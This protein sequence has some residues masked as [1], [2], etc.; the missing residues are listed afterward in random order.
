VLDP[1]CGCGTAI[2]VAQRLGRQWIGVDL[3]HIAIAIIRERMKGLVLKVHGEP[4][5][6]AGARQLARD[7]PYGFHW[8]VLGRVGARPRERKEGAD[9]GV[10]GDLFFRDDPRSP[11]KRI[12]FSVEGGTTGPLHVRELRAVTDRGD[13]AMGVLVTMQEPTQAMVVDAAKAGFYESPWGRHP[14][15]QILPVDQILGGRGPSYPASLGGVKKAR[16]SPPENE[17][18]RISRR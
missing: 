7:D 9:S 14:R 13:A 18:M 11:P 16:R 1:F 17:Q 5:D 12:V 8:W 4:D 10:D 6:M 15:I 3:K 2:A